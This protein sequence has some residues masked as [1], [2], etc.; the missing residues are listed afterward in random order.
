MSVQISEDSPYSKGGEGEW[1]LWL[2]YRM[3]VMKVNYHALNN[4]CTSFRGFALQYR[5]AFLSSNLIG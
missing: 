1:K 2:S 3:K 5:S 4:V